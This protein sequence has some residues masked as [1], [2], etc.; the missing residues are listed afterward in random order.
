METLVK[1]VAIIYAALCALAI[2]SLIFEF[3]IAVALP[4]LPSLL[5]CL[6]IT[7]LPIAPLAACVHLFYDENAALSREQRVGTFFGLIGISAIAPSVYTADAMYGMHWGYLVDWILCVSVVCTLW[8]LFHPYVRLSIRIRK[9]RKRQNRLL[10]K[11]ADPFARELE[12]RLDEMNLR[13]FEREA[14]C[15]FVQTVFQ[16]DVKY[17]L[18]KLSVPE[19]DIWYTNPRYQEVSAL[20]TLY[21]TAFDSWEKRQKGAIDACLQSCRALE[22]HLIGFADGLFRVN[23]GSALDDAQAAVVAVMRPFQDP[24]LNSLAVGL[25]IRET[26]AVNVGKV[27]ERL[28]VRRREAGAQLMPPEFEGTPAQVISAYL[29]GTPLKGL[30]DLVFPFGIPDTIRPEHGYIVGRSGGGKSQLIEALVHE[31]LSL[32]DP[33]SIIVID[34]KGGETGL[35]ERIAR[36]AAFDPDNGRLRER[37]IIIDPEDKP[38]LNIFAVEDVATEATEAIESLRYF[39]GGLLGN[40]LSNQMNM[41]FSPL[42]HIMLRTEGA[43][44][45]DFRRM[46]TNF[47]PRKEPYR[48]IL[49]TIPRGAREFMEEYYNDR[50]NTYSGTKTG[51]VSR[52]SEIANEER[53]YD[54]FGAPTNAF[55]MRRAIDGGAIILI[56][57][58]KLGPTHGPLFGRF[59]VAQLYA[60]AISRSTSGKRVHLYIDEAEQYIDTNFGKIFNQLRSYNVGA[61]VAFQNAGQMGIL[62]DTIRA[63]TSFQFVGSVRENDAKSFAGDMGVSSDFIMQQRVGA[64]TRPPFVPFVGKHSG[65]PRAVAV[66]VPTGLMERNTMSEA[67]YQKLRS[68]N[69]LR[70]SGGEHRSESEERQHAVVGPLWSRFEAAIKGAGGVTETGAL[71][72]DRLQGKL[73]EHEIGQAHLVRLQR[74][75]LMRH[76]SEPIPDLQRWEAECHN[77]IAILTDS[78]PSPPGD[79]RLAPASSSRPR[80]PTRMNRTAH[81]DPDNVDITPR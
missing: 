1:L 22:H 47:D 30:F 53:L 40:A 36:Q 13:A 41:L 26:W 45:G 62:S 8:L 42:M 72:I 11:Y 69:R 79:E 2:L 67:L 70:M 78:E 77:I 21:G 74:N 39:M 10:R 50:E 64:D 57:T 29:S 61:T 25:S 24:G 37:L 52:I 81:I 23:V 28:P 65:I 55:N 7:L 6:A 46:V 51:I 43:T 4:A 12:G 5:L 20:C 15:T 75:A 73:T 76:P 59:F 80:V 38:A 18:S 9:L 71:D 63:S 19:F 35:V 54:L 60:A 27:S 48:S 68:A 66:R 31:D 14:V 3:F 33:P 58:G 44:L 17:I 56:Q 16:E 49:P 34:S 32:E